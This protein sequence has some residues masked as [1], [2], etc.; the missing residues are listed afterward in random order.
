MGM[1]EFVLVLM[2][3]RCAKL[4]VMCSR[5]AYLCEALVGSVNAVGLHSLPAVAAMRGHGM[6]TSNRSGDP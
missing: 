3:L 5:N 6:M 1:Q 2:P 4:Q